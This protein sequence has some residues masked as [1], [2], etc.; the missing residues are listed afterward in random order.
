[1]N[2]SKA[3]SKKNCFGGGFKNFL[4][5]F[6]LKKNGVFKCLKPS[7]SSPSIIS[8]LGKIYAIM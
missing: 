1:M 6:E 3:I 8:H 2:G 4:G 7:G 5:I